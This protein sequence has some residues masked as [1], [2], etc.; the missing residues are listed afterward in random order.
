MAAF[1]YWPATGGACEACGEYF[2]KGLDKHVKACKGYRMLV[3]AKTVDIAKDDESTGT[4][5]IVATIVQDQ[6][7]LH[8]QNINGSCF[9][10]P[11]GCPHQS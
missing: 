9:P 6:V 4:Q 7:C 11:L 8:T 1:I 2:E 10:T 5:S 3:P